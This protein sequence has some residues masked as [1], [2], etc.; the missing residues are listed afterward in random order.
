MTSWKKMVKTTKDIEKKLKKCETKSK[1]QS[2]LFVFH[3]LFL[4]MGIY[5][6]VEPSVAID[7]LQVRLN[8]F[9][10]FIWLFIDNI[11][12]KTYCFYIFRSYKIVMNTILTISKTKKKTNSIGSKL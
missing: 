12:N 10:I 3:T 4:Q 2:I 7:T 5:L 11:G 9:N 6:F 1:E 8:S